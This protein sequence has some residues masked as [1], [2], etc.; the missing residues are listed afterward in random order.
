MKRLY[1]LLLA[2]SALAGCTVGPDYRRP[3][4]TAAASR[5][6]LE[7]AAPGAVDLK[8]WQRFGDP[9]LTAL[10]ERTIANAPDLK[11]ARARLAEARASRDVTAGSRLPTVNATGSATQNVLSENGQL[12]I[13]NI[14]GFE[15][16]FPLY[17]AGFDASW[18]IDLWGRRT[19][20]AQAAEA[21]VES[22]EFARR[23]V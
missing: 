23:D 20:Q 4:A 15:R 14:P 19:R 5:D 21:R 22:A 8:W 6:W 18:E 12:P 3:A 10:V 9:T 17:D 13:A 11:E 16:D 2:A 1:P 7:P